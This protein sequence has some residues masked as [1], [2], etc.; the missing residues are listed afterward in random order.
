MTII[1]FCFLAKSGLCHWAILPKMCQKLN[2]SQIWHFLYLTRKAKV[3]F[4]AKKITFCLLAMSKKCQFS[5]KLSFW[6]IFGNMAQWHFL[7][8]ARKQEVIFFTKESLFIYW[9]TFF[10]GQKNRLQYYTK[11]TL[12]NFVIASRC[13]RF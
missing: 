6:P 4:F 10:D 8:L 11:T 13:G 1:T 2:F 9:A 3:I 7:D 12:E 5:T